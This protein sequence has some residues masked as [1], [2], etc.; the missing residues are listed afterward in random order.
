GP[1]MVAH[2]HDRALFFLRLSTDPDAFNAESSKRV[3]ALVHNATD[4]VRRICDQCHLQDTGAALFTDAALQEA[5]QETQWLT[6]TSTIVIFLLIAFVF[7]SLAPHLLGF[8]QLFSSVVAAGATVIAVFGSINILTL[9]FGTTLLGIAIDYVFLF[10]LLQ[11]FGPCTTYRELL[12]FRV[13]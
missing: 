5:E 9:V 7:R 6:I 1:F 12:K 13:Q 3:N 2:K 8:L 4:Q 10:I 11:W